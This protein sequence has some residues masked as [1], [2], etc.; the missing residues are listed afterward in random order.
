M[1]EHTEL[2]TL[3]FIPSGVGFEL[4]IHS[5]LTGEIATTFTPPFDSEKASL[6]IERALRD[7][8]WVQA[9]QVIGQALY[10]AL[11]KAG[12][13][14]PLEQGLNQARLSKGE[15]LVLEMCFEGQAIDN[16]VNNLQ[17][18]FHLFCNN[19]PQSIVSLLNIFD[20]LQ[21]RLNDADLFTVGGKG[22]EDIRDKIIH[23]RKS[24]I[25]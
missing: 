15:P 12:T 20:I 23:H 13:G 21:G 11:K 16:F 22:Q 6:G 18:Y 5:P 9:Q 3:Q 2:I 25:T 19:L 4:H 14:G 17:R 8:T 10:N 24:G 1:A 7:G